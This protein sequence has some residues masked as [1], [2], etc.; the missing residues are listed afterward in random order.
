MSDRLDTILAF[1][2]P[3]FLCLYSSPALVFPIPPFYPI[4]LFVGPVLSLVLYLARSS[5]YCTLVSIRRLLLP[6][7]PHVLLVPATFLHALHA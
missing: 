2:P 1:F 4:V 6:Y 5:T 7:S 3:I